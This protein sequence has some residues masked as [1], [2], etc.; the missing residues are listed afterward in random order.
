MKIQFDVLAQGFLVQVLAVVAS[1]GIYSRKNF[2]QKATL[3][4]TRVSAVENVF[5]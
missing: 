4:V 5:L 2:T 1:F 3:T